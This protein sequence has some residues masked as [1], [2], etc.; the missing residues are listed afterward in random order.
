VCESALV[1]ALRRGELGGAVLD[2][3]ATEPLP[4]ASPLWGLP[5]AIV[6]PHVAGLGERWPAVA[7]LAVENLDRYASGRPPRNLVDLVAG[8]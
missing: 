6:T 2:V 5:R 4:P 3:F 7:D 8:Y 1:D